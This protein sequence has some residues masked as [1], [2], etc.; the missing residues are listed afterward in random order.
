MNELRKVAE[1][2]GEKWNMQQRLDVMRAAWITTMVEAS[3]HGNLTR[4]NTAVGLNRK[5]RTKLGNIELGKKVVYYQKE[6]GGMTTDK[7]GRPRNFCAR[8]VPATVVSRMNS[9]YSLRPGH[10]PGGV[11]FRHRCHI[12]LWKS[13]DTEWKAMVDKINQSGAMG[14]RAANRALQNAGSSDV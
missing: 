14:R 9:V 5:S 12:R 3:A 1:A 13:T 11:V 10:R 2:D 4:D 6:S 8:W 7:D